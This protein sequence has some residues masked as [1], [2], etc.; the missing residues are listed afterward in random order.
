M[1]PLE[2]S[3]ISS[4]CARVSVHGELW[5]FPLARER[6][7]VNLRTQ[8]APSKLTDVRFSVIRKPVRVGLLA[9]GFARV[10]PAQLAQQVENMVNNCLREP[11][12]TVV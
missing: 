12:P 7:L 9:A 5:L 10:A 1:E 3:L 11:Q 2:L 6:V 8:R 4:V